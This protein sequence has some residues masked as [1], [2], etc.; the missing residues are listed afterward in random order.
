MY[1]YTSATYVGF[2]ELKQCYHLLI[3]WMPTNYQSTVNQ[4]KD[5]LSDDQI[6][7]ILNSSHFH[8]ANQK[9]LNYLIEK[10]TIKEQLTELCDQLYELYASDF[11]KEV[12]K[13][14]KLG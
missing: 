12:V 7:S 10:I 6:A 14:L 5:Y 13:R 4:L 1:V 9:I 3:Q 2:S 8:S 11:M